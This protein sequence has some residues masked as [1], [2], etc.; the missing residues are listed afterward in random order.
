MLARSRWRPWCVIPLGL[1]LLGCGGDGA[2]DP[3]GVQGTIVMASGNHQKGNLNFPLW[4]PLTVRVTDRR[5]QGVENVEVTWTIA[6]G[7]GLLSPASG[8]APPDSVYRSL[9]DAGGSTATLLTPTVPGVTRVAAAAT[10]FEGTPVT[11]TAEA[12]PPDWPQVPASSLVY[13]RTTYDPRAFPC[14]Y[15]GSYYERYVLHEDGTFALQ[16]SCSVDGF[17]EYDGAFT[18]E[19]A[20]IA[21]DFLESAVTWQATGTVSGDCLAVQYNAQ[22]GLS[23]FEDGEFCRRS[24]TS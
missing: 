18:R 20:L 12:F 11:F 1:H 15:P 3:P 5:G 13:E 2:T 14:E 10:G 19:S 23:G 7:G 16:F 6:S 8:D 17:W 22:M 21:F 24:E 4:E 9:T